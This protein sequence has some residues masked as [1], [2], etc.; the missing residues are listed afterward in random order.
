MQFKYRN[1]NHQHRPEESSVIWIN[2]ISNAANQFFWTQCSQYAILSLIIVSPEEK[3]LLET[4]NYCHTITRKRTRWQRWHPLLQS[5]V[6][7]EVQIRYVC[8]GQKQW[9]KIMTDTGYFSHYFASVFQ[10]KNQEHSQN[11]RSEPPLYVSS[12]YAS[13]LI[14]AHKYRYKIQTKERFH[15]FWL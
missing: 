14:L 10:A 11:T 15:S 5:A 9:S 2:T 3:P 7:G 8:H 6:W 12:V 1:E 13:P 4:Y